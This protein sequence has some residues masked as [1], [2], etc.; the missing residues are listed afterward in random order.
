M[1]NWGERL[2]L[3]FSISWLVFSYS[4]DNLYKNYFSVKQD[5]LPQYKKL[6]RESVILHHHVVF[7]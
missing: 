6:Y 1:N 7:I 3:S 4:L 2:S 5:K